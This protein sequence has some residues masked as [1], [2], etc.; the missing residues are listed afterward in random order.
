VY[1]LNAPRLKFKLPHHTSLLGVVEG[2]SLSDSSRD[3]FGVFRPAIRLSSSFKVPV[4]SFSRREFPS[5]R[6]RECRI[7]EKLKFM[8]GLVLGGGNNEN[9]LNHF[10]SRFGRRANST[11]GGSFHAD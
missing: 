9:P 1:F 6:F 2:L 4:T 3:N 5:L 8:L 11:A 10:P 7:S